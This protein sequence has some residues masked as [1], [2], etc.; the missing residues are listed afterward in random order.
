[1]ACHGENKEKTGQKVKNHL[2]YTPG[3]I[4]MIQKE[5]VIKKMTDDDFIRFIDSDSGLIW[6]RK[7]G[8]KDIELLNT[9]N[10]TGFDTQGIEPDHLLRDLVWAQQLVEEEDFF[11]FKLFIK[12]MREGKKAEAIFRLQD[13][14][15]R[16]LWWKV[17]GAPGITN[18]SCYYGYIQDITGN[19]SFINHLLEKDLVRQ[20]M[21]ETEQHPVLLVDMETRAIISGNTHAFQLF[22][23]TYHEFNR[24]KFPD[25][26]TP[27][28]VSRVAKIYEICLLEG[29]WEGR[30]SLV[31]QGNISIEARIKIKRLALRER[32][33]LRVSIEEIRE[34]DAAGVEKPVGQFPDREAFERT[35]EAAIA[36]K[37]Q[38]SQILDTLLEHPYSETRFDGVMYADVYI[39]KG[40]VD[41]YGRG[42]VFKT[43]ENA[44]SF[45]YEGT[46][47]PLI[48]GKHLDYVI[49]DDTLESTRPID[50]ALFI[51]YGIRSYFAKPFFHGDKLRTLLIFCAAEP[52]R[53]SEA[54]LEIYQVYYPAFLKGLRNWRKSKKKKMPDR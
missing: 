31:K 26:F 28:H 35:L 53:F 14:E 17:N 11:R 23:Y 51:P 19:V 37:D 49:V 8:K 38:I 50:W 10:V 39:K 33:L 13:K 43:L 1:M 47:S 22:G 21:I 46:I 44:T 42:D 48:W 15:G 30:F 29:G 41:V 16:R 25:L 27:D 52:H 4:A 5:P 40:R 7:T 12:S 24:M 36:G 34:K 18:P 3:V 6:W 54:D 20:T 45:D 32:N 9:R 2:N